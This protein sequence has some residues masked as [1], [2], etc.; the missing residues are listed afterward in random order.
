MNI[1]PLLLFCSKDR[2]KGHHL[3]ERLT[4]SGGHVDFNKELFQNEHNFY[5]YK[6]SNTAPPSVNLVNWFVLSRVLPVTAR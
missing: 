1:K 3:I 5:F 2:Q 6:G 4:H